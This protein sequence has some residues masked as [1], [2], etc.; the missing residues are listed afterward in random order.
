MTNIRSIIQR[1][2]HDALLFDSYRVLCYAEDLV[3]WRY[4]T[5]CS[6]IHID[7]VVDR[8]DSLVIDIIRQH[9]RNDRHPQ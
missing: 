5:S 6:T 3:P 2:I 8:A 9:I 7:N 4:V 1:G